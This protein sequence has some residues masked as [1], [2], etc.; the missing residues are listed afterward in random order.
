MTTMSKV[1]Y[2]FRTNDKDWSDIVFEEDV[3]RTWASR[4]RS[5]DGPFHQRTHGERFGP[6]RPLKDAVNKA[7]HDLTQSDVG[8]LLF[9]ANKAGKGVRGRR[10]EYEIKLADTTGNANIDLLFTDI[11]Q[12]FNPGVQNMG[13]QVCK[14]V[15]TTSTPSQHSAWSGLTSTVARQYG[16]ASGPDSAG[17]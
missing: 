14:T 17:G 13:A 4:L 5:F 16:F 1:G 10:I 15:G 8:F 3:R 7:D 11:L 12:N 6:Y 2:R 9:V